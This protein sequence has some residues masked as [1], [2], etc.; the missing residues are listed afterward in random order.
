MMAP[1]DVHSCQLLTQP[2]RFSATAVSSVST[3]DLRRE[4]KESEK[5]VP[6]MFVA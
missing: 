6:T 4:L 3:N 1:N 5:F 2:R